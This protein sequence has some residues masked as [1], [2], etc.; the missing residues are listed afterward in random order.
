MRLKKLVGFLFS[1]MVIVGL[2]ILLQFA[3]IVVSIAY[4]STTTI[5]LYPVLELLSLA[6]VLWI[7]ASQDNPS[8][9]IAWIIAI[10]VFPLFGG[11]FYLVWGNKTLNK[12]MRKKL[13]VSVQEGH[14]YLEED[15]NIRQA[16]NELSPQLTVQSDYIRNVS[17]FP[18]CRNTTARYF[19]VGEEKFEALKQELMKAKKFILLEYFI[20][21]PG[22][23]WDTVFDILKQKVT[24]GVEVRLMYDDVG[25]LQ[26]LPKI[27]DKLIQ[28][29]GIK[30]T[31]F[32]P[33][34]PRLNAMMNYRDHR[35]ICVIDGNVGF[36][37]GINLA[38][39][40][41]NVYPKLGH[42]KD[43]AV[44][45]T[46]DGVW[47]FTFMFL[48]LWKYESGEDIEFD[49]YRPT[50]SC[51]DAKGFVQPFGDSPLDNY[52]VSENAY[53]HM[54][55]RATRYVYITTPYLILDNEMITA[56]SM[57]AQSGVDV[58]IMTPH[59]PD[60]WYVHMV[61]QSYYKPLL[62]AGV[63]IMEYTPGFVHAKMFVV[64]D[65]V[66]IVGTTNLDFR[67]LYLHFEC[68]VVFYEAPVIADVKKDILDTLQVCTN[69]TLEVAKQISLPKR[70]LRSFLR[71]FAPMM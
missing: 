6:V 52:N 18:L 34:R 40:Y 64:D 62:E 68:G 67:S 33:F 45:L 17:D 29:A 31:V 14:Q 1:R 56:L 5:Y 49:R 42:W 4:L 20:L 19:K 36:C 48:Q 23:M 44:M 16:L 32:N 57:A 66:A 59:I 70:I 15:S 47:N 21:E 39:E 26:T 8:Y 30:L 7:V 50:V 12:K 35:K 24:E 11:L 58:R 55:N 63:T 25:S 13:E 3:F 69:I 10:F 65:R 61:T 28:N 41:I 37:G 53:L 60:K 51:T 22:K 27:Y 54:I 9:K 46:G 38:D 2:L 43:T 71:L